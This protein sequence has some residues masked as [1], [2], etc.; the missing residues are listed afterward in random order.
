MVVFVV[1]AFTPADETGNDDTLGKGVC[2]DVCVCVCVCFRLHSYLLP[3]VASSNTT[4][5]L[6]M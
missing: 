5:H 3:T 4:G 1:V 2:A 6:L